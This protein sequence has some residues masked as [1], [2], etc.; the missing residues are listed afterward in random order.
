MDETENDEDTLEACRNRAFELL[1]RPESLDEG[2]D[3]Y[4]YYIAEKLRSYTPII[5][6]TVQ[7]QIMAAINNI[8][9]ANNQ[10]Q[11]KHG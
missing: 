4:G 9:G 1:S 2:F 6:R 8:G 10:Q 5:R 11:R 3:A 7:E